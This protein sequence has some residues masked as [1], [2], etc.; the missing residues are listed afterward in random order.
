MDDSTHILNPRNNVHHYY[1]KNKLCIILFYFSNDEI[2]KKHIESSYLRIKKLHYRH[3]KDYIYQQPS[4]LGILYLYTVV[5]AGK[6][7]KQAGNE[8][9][10]VLIIH[11]VQSI[12]RDYDLSL[13]HQS[14]G[15]SKFMKF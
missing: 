11:R 14:I 4:A 13:T 5:Y 7:C 12:L 15:P 8:H 10:I 6:L 1:N 2:N 9:I 3:F